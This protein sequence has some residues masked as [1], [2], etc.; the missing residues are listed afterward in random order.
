MGSH[1][2]DSYGDDPLP[3]V[4]AN[5]GF[6]GVL[7]TRL[8]GIPPNVGSI[9]LACSH[10]QPVIERF[11]VFKCGKFDEPRVDV[12][13]R[14]GRVDHENANRRA[15]AQGTEPLLAFG[16]VVLR[17]AVLDCQCGSSRQDFSHRLVIGVRT[18]WVPVIQR[19][20]AEDRSGGR[21]DR[22]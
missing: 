6:A 3:S 15:P 5:D 17:A 12:G 2:S 19:E 21:K 11:L 20:S 14:A 9:G 7:R 22:S 10:F 8:D 16:Q 4:P 18:A 13:E 1:W